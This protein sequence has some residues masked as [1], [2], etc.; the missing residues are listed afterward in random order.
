MESIV[1][2]SGHIK[3]DN[4]QCKV[5]CL[6]AISALSGAIKASHS[7]GSLSGALAAKRPAPRSQS[8]LCS[9]V[10]EAARQT[11]VLRAEVTSRKAKNLYLGR[12]L[13]RQAFL[14]RNG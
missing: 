10:R 8:L 5:T 12:L 4:R 1:R 2:A 7:C 6:N 13:S 11:R 9:G 14:A 3:S